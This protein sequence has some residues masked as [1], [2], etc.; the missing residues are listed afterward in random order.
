M[1]ERIH[2][3]DINQ[4]LKFTS[5]IN[6]EHTLLTLKTIDDFNGA[7]VN[8]PEYEYLSMKLKDEP[9]LLACVNFIARRL[10]YFK[11]MRKIVSIT[12]RFRT[13]TLKLPQSY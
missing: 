1:L 7:N 12:V 4:Q 6:K 11:H 13:Q 9:I 2:H 10:N 8:I 3:R 5:P